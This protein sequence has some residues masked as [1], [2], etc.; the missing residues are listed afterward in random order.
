MSATPLDHDSLDVAMFSL[1]LMGHNFTEYLLEAHRVLKIDGQLHI[2]EA[3]S[4]FDDVD[5]FCVSLE[6]LGFKAFPPETKGKFTHVSAQK[7]TRKPHPDA[8]M[9]F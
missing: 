9:V 6:Q 3:T 4:R 8:V 1:S 7:T 2:W 5:S